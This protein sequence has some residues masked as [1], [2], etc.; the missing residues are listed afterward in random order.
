MKRIAALLILAMACRQE[1]STYQHQIDEYRN[2]RVARLT[3]AEGWLSVVALL[4]LQDGANDVELPSK[5]SKHAKVTL[6]QGRVT[7]DPDSAF[8]VDSK[9][10]VGPVELHNDTEDT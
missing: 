1:S 5:P 6:Q 4:P 9:P 3:R 10:V 7:L 8:T 2:Q